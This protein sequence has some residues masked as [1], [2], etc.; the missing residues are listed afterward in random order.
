MFTNGISLV[1]VTCWVVEPTCRAKLMTP[2]CVTS[3]FRPVRFSVLN[4]AAEAVIS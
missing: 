1:M 3:R 2:V 4:P